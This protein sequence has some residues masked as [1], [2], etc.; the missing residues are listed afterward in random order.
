[1]TD[2]SKPVGFSLDLDQVLKD[3]SGTTRRRR[4]RPATNDM[5]AAVRR[6]VRTEMDDVERV[7]KAL[8]AEV[9]RLRKSNE[10]LDDR[11]ARLLKR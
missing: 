5:D 11:I 3:L 6:A 8:V 4:A 10:D 2:S 7:L 1:M 9:A